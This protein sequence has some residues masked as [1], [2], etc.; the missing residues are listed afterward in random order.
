M[1]TS[2]YG[3]DVKPMME[4]LSEYVSNSVGP[5]AWK[6]FILWTRQ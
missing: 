6:S 5:E 2:I 1:C 4:V 3:N